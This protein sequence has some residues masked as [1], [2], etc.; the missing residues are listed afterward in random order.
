MSNTEKLREYLIGE[1]G[2]L[3]NEISKG[4]VLMLSGEWGSGKTHFWK[5]QLE[6]KLTKGQTPYAYVSLYGK[7]NIESLE[8]DTFMNIYNSVVGDADIISK[9]CS[10]S[11]SYTKKI[12]GLFSTAIT[13]L[14]KG[15]VK[16][17]ISKVATDIE[18]LINDDKLT[19]AGQFLSRGG[20]ICF[21]DFERKSKDID[22]NDLFGFITQLALNFNSKIVL[23]LN[24]DVFEGKEKDIFTNVKEKTVSKYLKFAPTCN[25]LFEIIIQDEKYTSLQ[26]NEE[27]KK[28]LK[29]TFD[30][31]GIVNARILIQIL[32]NVLE[33]K[34]REKTTSDFYLRYFVLSNINFIL[35]HHVFMA[36][37]GGETIIR[38]STPAG[39]RALSEEQHEPAET[40]NIIK[41]SVK[42]DRN[43]LYYIM[44]EKSSNQFINNLKQTIKVNENTHKDS[45]NNGEHFISFIE[46]HE[47]L[48]K[49]IHFLISFKIHE[50]H[51]SNNNAEVETLNQINTF[52]ETG[53]I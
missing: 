11:L 39:I 36:Q 34:N 12:G 43:I 49:S 6:P 9:M 1:N 27:I 41:S 37:L 22:L 19:K 46:Q 15:L 50:Y 45:P 52:I 48:I 5:N 23:I 33:W 20:I 8:I 14:T 31:V 35:N 29:K 40:N 3:L 16:T 47:S 18:N 30:E 42:L 32:D 44:H 10:T 17:D 7:T 4:K 13:V 51:E 38:M 2:Y 53:I 26:N 28:L 24:S 21:D 25:E